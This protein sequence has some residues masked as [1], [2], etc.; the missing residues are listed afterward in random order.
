MSMARIS[1]GSSRSPTRCWRRGCIEVLHPFFLVEEGISPVPAIP[2]RSAAVRRGK[3]SLIRCD[4]GPEYIS[5]A[6]LA[7]PQ[8]HDI[9]IEHFQP[10]KPQQNAHVERYNRT[11]RY[12]WLARTP[13]RHHRTDAGAGAGADKAMHWHRIYSHKRPIWCS[14]A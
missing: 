4:N 8:P 2:R 10:G 3:P 12:A 7:W 11:V 6:L 9:R 1:R 5:G 13:V 14:A